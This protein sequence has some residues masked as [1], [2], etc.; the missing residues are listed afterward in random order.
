VLAVVL[1]AGSA[2]VWGSSDFMGGK[3]S[4]HANSF[5]VALASQLAGLPA[6]AVCLV[7]LPVPLASSDQLLR[8]VPAGIAGL[9]GIVLLYRALA[10][11]VMS[12]VAP[13]TAVTAAVI[14][15]AVGLV[16]DRAPSA[17]A[18]LGAALAIVAIGLTS[19]G[20]SAGRPTRSSIGF[21][22]A[23]GAMF[24]LFFVLFDVSKP[25]DGMWPLVGERVA[26]IAVGLAALA[27]FRAS[28]RL[29]RTA[30]WWAVPG[31]VGDVVAT[32][33]Y[34]AAAQRGSLAIVGP[35]SAL[36]PASTVVLALLVQRERLRPAQVAGLGLA[37]LA[38]VLITAP[39]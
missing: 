6:I 7:A 37:A 14:P 29:P 2:L 26:A 36:Y 17:L 1:A 35:V 27:L 19:S 10:D 16:I 39:S 24:G 38:L 12:V 4:Q 23:A 32:A 30:L 15:L 33:L 28:P 25:S 21:A 34:L 3:A 8:G 11:G 13:V 9:F 22:L 18:I 5:A 20:P 31:G